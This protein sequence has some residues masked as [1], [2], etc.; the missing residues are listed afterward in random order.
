MAPLTVKIGKVATS[1]KAFDSFDAS[2]LPEFRLKLLQRKKVT[3]SP[4]RITLESRTHAYDVAK[5]KIVP[6]SRPQVALVF[7]VAA[8][9]PVVPCS[10]L[11]SNDLAMMH[12]H[13]IAFAAV[14][15]VSLFFQKHF[16]DVPMRSTRF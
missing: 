7:P 13:H 8:P 3:L 4:S 12:R 9:C 16:L 14:L 2:N 15:S 11:I 5:E 1:T 10:H 6:P